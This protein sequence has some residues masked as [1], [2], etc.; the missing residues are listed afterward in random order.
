M[1]NENSSYIW[2]YMGIVDAITAYL[3]VEKTAG[4]EQVA[5]GEKAFVYE[6]HQ[7]LIS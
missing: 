3:V 1:Q 4:D 6:L 2:G 5:V 7:S